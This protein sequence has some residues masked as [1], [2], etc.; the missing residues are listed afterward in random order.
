MFTSMS[1]FGRSRNSAF[2]KFALT[3]RLF[4][5]LSKISVGLALATGVVLGGVAVAVDINSATQESLESVKGIGSTRAKLIIEE[6]NKN[7][8]YKSAEDLSQRVRGVGDK[9]VTKLREQG[10]TF[11]SEGQSKAKNS[12]IRNA[13]KTVDV[14]QEAGSVRPSRQ[15]T[16]S[17]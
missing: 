10:L 9:T 2:R 6:R 5:K 1:L 17:E 13:S 11:E 3:K 15:K 7:G 16:K 4:K 8:A 12:R 14:S